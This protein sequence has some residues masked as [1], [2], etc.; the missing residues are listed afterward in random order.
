MSLLGNF[1]KTPNMLPR[2]PMQLF[3]MI[4]GNNP[5]AKQ[6]FNMIQTITQGNTEKAKKL[7]IDKIQKSNMSKEE[8]QKFKSTAKGLGVDDNTLDM[9]EKYIK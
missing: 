6:T 5:E 8:F 9:L 2:N 4:M 1:N 3:Q 7:V